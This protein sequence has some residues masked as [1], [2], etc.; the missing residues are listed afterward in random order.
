MESLL[1]ECKKEEAAPVLDD[2]ALNDLLARRYMYILFEGHSH[3]LNFFD[4]DYGTPQKETKIFLLVHSVFRGETTV[5]INHCLH[6]HSESEID[7][8]ETVDKERQEHE[9]VFKSTLLNFSLLFIV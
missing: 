5:F 7:V 3:C 1:R 8:F 2:D 9:M 4:T 6:V